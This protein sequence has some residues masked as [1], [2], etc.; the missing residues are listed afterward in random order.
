MIS[1]WSSNCF[2]LCLENSKGRCPGITKVSS[3]RSFLHIVTVLSYAL[4]TW[5]NAIS[6]M[7]GLMVVCIFY[8]SLPTLPWTPRSMYINTHSWLHLCQSALYRRCHWTTGMF[9]HIQ[10]IH[11]CL[12]IV[13]MLAKFQ[14]MFGRVTHL[15]T[16]SY[17]LMFCYERC[18]AACSSV[19]LLFS[20]CW[21][22]AHY[23]KLVLVVD[24]GLIWSYGY[25]DHWSSSIPYWLSDWLKL[26]RLLQQIMHPCPK[27]P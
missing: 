25:S 20:S 9:P 26:F 14:K 22:T 23:S 18:D 2:M 12:V 13:T 8:F 10:N 21:G 19:G 15:A 24:S 5:L 6:K 7:E 16:P 17:L 4:L 11:W 3:L 27:L 1:S